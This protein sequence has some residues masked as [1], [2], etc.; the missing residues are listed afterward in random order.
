MAKRT[1]SEQ[2]ISGTRLLSPDG[3]R[4]ALPVLFM[5]PGMKDVPADWLSPKKGDL[6][7]ILEQHCSRPMLIVLPDMGGG[8]GG[9]PPLEEASKRY[10]RAWRQLAAFPTSGRHGIVG[11]SMGARQALA[12]ALQKPAGGRPKVSALGLLSGMFQREEYVTQVSDFAGR[13]H[14]GFARELDLYF[15]YCGA[16]PDEGPR[17]GDKKFL[18]SNCCLAAQAGGV[19][20]LESKGM[21][22]WNHW[23]PPLGRFF[24]E[25]SALW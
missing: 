3:T 1:W 17:G 22:N 11:I 5:F 25:L 2:T 6:R 20:E 8:K 13:S 9:M 7:R 4:G 16:A 24:E 12:L 14:N 23:R 10:E 18:P 21:H 15:H 19:L